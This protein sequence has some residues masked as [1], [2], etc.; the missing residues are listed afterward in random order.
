MVNN[1]KTAPPAKEASRSWSFHGIRLA[2]NRFEPGERRPFC[3]A[4]PAGE[5]MFRLVFCL[6]GS[7]RSTALYGRAGDCPGLGAG[8]CGLFGHR[9]GCPCKVCSCGRR[10]R[11]VEIEFSLQG[12]ARL[13]DG[14]DGPP[15]A[16]PVVPPAPVTIKTTP[17][18]DGLLRQI[19]AE[20]DA[21][22]TAPLILMSRSLE[23]IWLFF[24][25]VHRAG[26]GRVGHGDLRAVYT[27][28][29]ILEQDLVSPPPL[30]ELAGRVGMSLSKFKT[31]F[32][33]VCG[34]PPYGYLR[35]VRLERARHLLSTTDMS[36]TQVALEV[37]YANP[38]KFSHAFAARFG[39]KPSRARRVG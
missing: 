5:E 29:A 14:G 34:H 38:S 36:V 35:C 37:G 19:E 32:P 10:A 26:Q 17:A 28:Q 6:D 18:M 21:V 20:S 12:L 3:R 24:K 30:S 1:L 31:V 27:A 2:C 13:M 8:S 11:T 39:F 9:K 22:P 16:M 15:A 23:L 25:T 33:R 7:L 4:L